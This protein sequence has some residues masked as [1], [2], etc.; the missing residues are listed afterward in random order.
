MDCIVH[1]L[2]NAMAEEYPTIELHY[3]RCVQVMLEVKEERWFT[4]KM[5]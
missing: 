3:K 2:E 4:S 5:H 1:L